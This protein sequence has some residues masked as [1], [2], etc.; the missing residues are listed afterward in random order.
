MENGVAEPTPHAA[1]GGEPAP[2]AARSSG[3]NWPLSLIWSLVEALTQGCC[4]GQ[5]EEGEHMKDKHWHAVSGFTPLPVA[6][7]QPGAF[8]RWLLVFT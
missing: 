3:G 6:P 7:Y 2:L 1:Q 5:R 8:F 4:L